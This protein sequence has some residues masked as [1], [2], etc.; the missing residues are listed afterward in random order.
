M[1][2]GVPPLPPCPECGVSPHQPPRP[3]RLIRSIPLLFLTAFLGS[4]AALCLTTRDSFTAGPGGVSWLLPATPLTRADLGAIA[5]IT[6]APDTR[7]AFRAAIKDRFRPTIFG[8]PNGD[9]L[10]GLTV[11]QSTVNDIHRR[12]WPGQWVTRYRFAERDNIYDPADPPRATDAISPVPLAM[13]AH[14]PYRSRIGLQHMTVRLAPE[15]HLES[16]YWRPTAA[17]PPMALVACVIL[18][19]RTF[20]RRTLGR[21]PV[22]VVLGAMVLGLYVALGW[23]HDS[24]YVWRQ[25]RGTV[26]S[27]VPPRALPVPGAPAPPLQAP[28]AGVPAREALEL[29]A[30]PEGVTELAAR[31][32]ALLPEPT[33]T[34]PTHVLALGQTMDTISSTSTLMGN[35]VM[36]LIV[37]SDATYASPP[38]LTR[39]IWQADEWLGVVLTSAPGANR[40]L[41]F[42]VNLE[43]LGAV[44]LLGIGVYHLGRLAAWVTQAR[45][46]RGRRRRGECLTCG[47]ALAPAPPPR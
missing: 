13:L 46:T 23:R 44:V 47:Y 18:V 31:L 36:P 34:D 17:L 26:A 28:P 3:A 1:S 24:T 27:I 38:P 14:G 22:L 4:I 45:R 37:V 20:F 40:L 9:L 35:M 21:W 25:T 41:G 5:T 33:A 6:A 7:E 15:G 29:I 19:V 11:P 43:A 12:G 16:T 2:D 10:P 42:S 8:P 39:P 30:T 32:R